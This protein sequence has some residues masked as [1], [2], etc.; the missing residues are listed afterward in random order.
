MFFLDKNLITQMQILGFSIL[1]IAKMLFAAFNGILFTQ[2]GF[3]K[4][5]D[6]Q[7]N[8][9]Y[10]RDYFKNS[11]LA[12]L[13]GLLMPIITLL[14]VSAG[15]VSL[16]GLALL[17]LGSDSAQTVAAWGMLLGAKAMVALFFGQRLA[18]D[19]AGAAGS[20]PYFLMAILGLI[21]YTL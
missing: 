7:G 4:V 6:Y 17:L 13:V 8:L 9:S 2:S 3:N 12:S 1:L 21:L 5:F 15:L 14:E 18:K 19:Y 20:V 10:F 16:L 11:P